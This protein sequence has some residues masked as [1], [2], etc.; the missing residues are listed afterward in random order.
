V[1][2][3]V[4]GAGGFLGAAV[5]RSLAADALPAPHVDLAD[6]AQVDALIGGLGGVDAV[7]HCAAATPFNGGDLAVNEPITRNVARLCN[8]LGVARLVFA[9]GW[10]VYAV[11][12]VPVREDDRLAPATPYG[13][14]KLASE[15]FFAAHLERTALVSV[16][17]A[18]VYGPGQLSPG[19]I[20]NLVSAGLETG[21]LRL[22]AVRTRRDYVHVDDAAEALRRLLAVPVDGR[23]DVNVGGGR[24]ASVL[25]VA[26]AV[27]D[28]LGDALEIEVDDPPR[29]ATPPD[30]VHDISRARELG[31]LG[32]PRPLAA[33]LA[34][35]VR[36]RR[37]L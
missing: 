6:R 3:L 11:D 2:A 26:G 9:S 27:A 23:L 36:W 16:R 33:G 7:V 12:R 31:V 30:N 25:E 34:D 18:S 5:V 28:A 10:V 32:E 24:S 14:S 8:E 35:Y 4:T 22:A 1:E 21:R 37:L 20:P 29:E 15:R 19:L 13:A 17:L